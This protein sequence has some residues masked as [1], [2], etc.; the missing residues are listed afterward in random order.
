GFLGDVRRATRGL[1]RLRPSLALEGLPESALRRSVT[2]VPAAAP[3]ARLLTETAGQTVT[4]RT[5]GETAPLGIRVGGAAEGVAEAAPVDP[6][7][8]LTELVRGIKKL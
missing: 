7:N 5:V 2:E 1:T 8:K 3:E 4:P 6:V